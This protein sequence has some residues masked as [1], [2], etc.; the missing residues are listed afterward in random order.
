MLIDMYVDCHRYEEHHLS[1]CDA[2]NVIVAVGL[3]NLGNIDGTR[4]SLEDFILFTIQ[5]FDLFD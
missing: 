2:I 5:P 1:C 3:D 4:M